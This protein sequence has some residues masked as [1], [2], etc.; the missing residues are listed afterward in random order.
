MVKMLQHSLAC[1][2]YFWALWATGATAHLRT[3]QGGIDLAGF[4]GSWDGLKDMGCFMEL[5]RFGM[6]TSADDILFRSGHASANGMPEVL[7]VNNP[8]K[9]TSAPRRILVFKSADGK[10]NPQAGTVCTASG[11][12][13]GKPSLLATSKAK[14]MNECSF[15][16]CAADVTATLQEPGT[17]YI[18][19]MVGATTLLPS[20]KSEERQFLSIGLGAGTLALLL[21]QSFPGSSQT[22]VELSPDVAAAAAC[23]GVGAN[24]DVT[25]GDGREYLE[26]AADASFD[27]VFL[28]AFDAS[29]KVPSCFTTSEF[30]NIA[31]RKLRS[32]GML[33]MNAHSGA[34]LHNDVA[35]LLPAANST[36]GGGRLQVGKAPGLANAIVL[37]QLAQAEQSDKQGASAFVQGVANSELSSWFQDATFA[38]IES[39]GAGRALTDADVKCSR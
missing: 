24:L 12:G 1:P 7:V 29:D 34:T 31:K 23:F 10:C 37:A 32:G 14:G 9:I 26:N 25:I 18:R 30:F 5:S 3:R 2:F 19:S 6:K 13:S 35:D 33:V 8:S 4:G 22:V 15:S 27:A 21:Q 36:F 20:A 28:D 38:P 17:G 39:T 11:S 16:T